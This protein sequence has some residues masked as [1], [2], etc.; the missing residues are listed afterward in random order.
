MVKRLLPPLLLSLVLLAVSLA[1]SARLLEAGTLVGILLALAVFGL[2]GLA[3]VL[4]RAR[5]RAAEAGIT[6]IGPIRLPDS[7]PQQGQA[8]LQRLIEERAAL[9]AEMLAAGI[10]LDRDAAGMNGAATGA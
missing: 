3:A 2:L 7:E 5:E 4:R 1:A 10:D 9:R 6:V 8:A